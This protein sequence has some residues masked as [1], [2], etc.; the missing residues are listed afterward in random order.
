[1]RPL[2]FPIDVTVLRYCQPP[3]W[4]TVPFRRERSDT[5][6]LNYLPPK[7]PRRRVDHLFGVQ[8][9]EHH[10]GNPKDLRWYFTAFR[11]LA[12][13]HRGPGVRVYRRHP[14]LRP[15]NERVFERAFPIEI[16]RPSSFGVR[17]DSRTG[18][19]ADSNFGLKCQPFGRLD[20]HTR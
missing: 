17:C 4:S 12:R 10:G 13:R 8:V 15:R 6:G 19:R 1:M 9:V 14:T 11:M 20:P 3:D 5:A 7:R 18:K 16:A 2:V